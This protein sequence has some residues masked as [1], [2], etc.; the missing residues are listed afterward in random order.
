MNPFY[1]IRWEILRFGWEHGFYTP[2]DRRVLEGRILPTFARDPTVSRLLFV[3]I[4]WYTSHLPASFGSKTFATIDPDPSVIPFGGKP[5][6]VGRV[7]DLEAHFPGLAFDAI[8]MTGVIGYGLDNR[9]DVDRAVTACAKALRPGGWLVLGVNELR[10]TY[11]DPSISPASREFD[12]RPIGEFTSARI[13]IPLP[14]KER[15]HTFLFWQKKGA[16]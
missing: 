1:W 6:V 16:P 10:P 15:W 13:D 9:Q 12:P 11:V 8:V 3:G 2:P 4:Q 7:Q 14:F 5:H